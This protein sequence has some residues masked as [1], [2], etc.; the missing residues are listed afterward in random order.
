MKTF[1]RILFTLLIS[2]QGLSQVPSNGL[3]GYWPFSGN[4]N[5]VSSLSNNGFGG[6]VRINFE[7][8]VKYANGNWKL[9]NLDIE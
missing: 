3:I 2:F 4:A 5:D 9:L 8:E 1:I 6:I 7:C